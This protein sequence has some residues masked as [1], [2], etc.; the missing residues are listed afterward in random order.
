MLR[1]IKW[2]EAKE[3]CVMRCKAEL[4]ASFS[5]SLPLSSGDWKTIKRLMSQKIMMSLLLLE[6]YVEFR[7]TLRLIV[8]TLLSWRWAINHDNESLFSRHV[9]GKT[10]NVLPSPE[11]YCDMRNKFACDFFS[12]QGGWIQKEEKEREQQVL[13][14]FIFDALD[15]MKRIRMPPNNRIKLTPT[16][17]NIFSSLDRELNY[18]YAK[19]LI[20]FYRASPV[21]FVLALWHFWCYF[22][23]DHVSELETRFQGR[24]KEQSRQQ[25]RVRF[26]PQLN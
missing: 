12:S 20:W 6:V 7:E 18:V 26:I 22:H 23:S 24:N 19:A 8:F 25:G 11:V 3:N 4:K 13:R 21:E 14:K 2:L 15:S 5:L 17:L 16:K 10:K 1:H 9:H